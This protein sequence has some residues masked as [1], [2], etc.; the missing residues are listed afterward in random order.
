[1]LFRSNISAISACLYNDLH[2]YLN[3]F[4]QVYQEKANS[5]LDGSLPV[6]MSF[7][8][9]WMSLAGLQGYERFYQALFLGKYYSPFKLNV[10]LAYDYGAP[11]KA[12]QIVPNNYTPAWGGEATWGAGGPWG[13][14]GL[15]FEARIF[16]TKQKCETFQLIINELYDPSLGAVAAQGLALSGLSLVVG[17]KKGYRVQKAG[18]TFG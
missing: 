17:V 4:G 10:Q 15:P 16:P 9:G 7:T 2:T 11:E 1:M 3:S 18:R 8:T 12:I 14:Q 5:Y 13:G 6:L